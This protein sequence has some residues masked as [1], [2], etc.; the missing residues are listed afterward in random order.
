MLEIHDK[1]P[2]AIS[3]STNEE[4][5]AKQDVARS[6]R[7]TSRRSLL[8]SAGIAGAGYL[9]AAPEAR[10]TA[11]EPRAASRGFFMVTAFGAAGDGQTDDT[12]SINAAVA[13]AGERG[14]TVYFPAGTYLSYSVRLMSRVTLEL[15][16]GC[17]IRAAEP[18][19]NIANGGFDLAEPAAT[20]EPYLDFGHSHW[21]NSLIW[22]EDLE[23]IAI[24]GQGLICGD[25]LSRGE[26]SGPQAEK[27]G[28]GN[29][30]VALKNCHNVLLRDFSILRG[31]HFAVLATGVDNLTIDNLKIDT[32]RDG[33][34]I[35]CCHNVRI[36]NCSINSP[37]DDAIVLKTSYAL[38]HLRST[39]SV[40]IAN[41]YVTGGYQVGTLLDATC[42][43]FVHDGIMP[44]DKWIRRIG[45]IK[46]GTESNGD[47]KNVAV[48]NCIFENS[49]GIAIESVDG[50]QIEDVVITNITM[51][52]IVT[53]PI[54]IRLG[55][56][57]RGPTGTTAGAIRRVVISNVVCSNS[58]SK[59][60]SV[61]AGIPEHPIEDITLSNIF[62]QHAGELAGEKSLLHIPELEQEYP[63]AAMFGVTPAQGLYVRHVRGLNVS[64]LNISAL[65]P[66]K[67]PLFA[68]QDVQSV[69]FTNIRSHPVA[70]CQTFSLK[71]IQDFRVA[72]AQF[73]PDT[74]LDWVTSKDL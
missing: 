62:V 2:S 58:S 51:K 16:P 9:M 57:L 71:N 45:R 43:P 36:S 1:M 10:A 26:G 13:A 33:I 8:K 47:F 15:S 32:N 46:L 66:D 42:K 74:I 67:R 19:A 22:G 55:S 6:L 34:D 4:D 25:N 48:S 44:N 50:G 12:K 37:W 60:A 39:E 3:T 40:S 68:L 17:T 23:G 30:T 70:G 41:C 27:P 11:A 29:K 65:K 49:F 14:G 20:T 61:I 63:E 53:C 24:V 38:G 72:L 18:A 56:R 73:I 54:F 69:M 52:N 31:G 35:D 5:N 64:G 28:A 7:A 21:H 59:Y